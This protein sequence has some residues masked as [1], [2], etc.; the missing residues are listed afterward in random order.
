MIYFVEDSKKYAQRQLAH[1]LLVY[2]L[3]REYGITGEILVKRKEKGKPY[4]AEYPDIYFNYSHSAKGVLC[5]IDSS[6]IGVDIEGVISYREPLAKKILHPS[7]R[8]M[9]S[10]VIEKEQLLT[11]I[12]ISKESYLKFT[13]D[14]IRSDLRQ[15]DFSACQADLFAAEGCRFELKCNEQFG[16]AVCGR[17]DEYHFVSVKEME[18]E[19]TS[20]SAVIVEMNHESS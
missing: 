19:K 5:G 4:L 16:M 9:L 1:M 13:G 8:D 7:E 6:E 15:L 10:A 14:G 3:Y 2:G 18:L 12:W 17:R 20:K 11:R